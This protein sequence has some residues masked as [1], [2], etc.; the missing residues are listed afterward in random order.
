MAFAPSDASST[1]SNTICT[2][3]V[4][5]A[6]GAYT[7]NWYIDFVVCEQMYTQAFWLAPLGGLTTA[8]VWFES[9]GGTL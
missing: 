4:G 3:L 2:P 8:T 7:I 9:G 1:T 6:L 5:A